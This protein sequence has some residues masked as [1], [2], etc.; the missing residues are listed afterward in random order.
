MPSRFIQPLLFRLAQSTH[1]E[2]ARQ[3]QFLKAENEIL[4][5]KLP[6]QIRT[7]PAERKRLIKLGKALGIALRDLIT[8]VS[9]SSF[10]R[11]LRDEDD[12]PSKPCKTGRPATQTDIRQLI[13]LL[14]TDNNWGYTRIA[15]ELGKLGHT[16]SR[17]TVKNILLEAGLDPSPKR[18]DSTWDTFIKR[19]RD[20]LWACDFLSCKVLTK[21]GFVEYF[22]LFF[23]H[24]SSRQVHVA[25]ITSH[26]H[27]AWMAQQARNLC[28]F[29]DEQP[30]KPIFLM[31]DGD[32]KFTAQFDEILKSEPHQ[33]IRLPYRSPNLNA[34][35][36]RWV[37]SLKYECL[38]H[39]MIFGESHLRYLID[40]YVAHYHHERPHQG[41]GNKPIS[42]SARNAGANGSIR[43]RER[44]GGLLKHYFRDAA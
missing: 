37:Q 4:R 7:T 6:N 25:G 9:Y 33:V 35:A 44:L 38:N 3:N 19:H 18:S 34:F 40:E 28:M 11:W 13:V 10:L 36:E 42:T 1:K 2:L 41:L 21:S 30:H 5:S 12:K 39:F 15:G 43:C 20:T 8:I 23:I 32:R 31:R 14:A 29:Y 26:P 22:V 24:V 17:S 27:G 16:I